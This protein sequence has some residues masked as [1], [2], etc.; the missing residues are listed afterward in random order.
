[1]MVIFD[2]KLN[3]IFKTF[4]DIFSQDQQKLRITPDNLND[5]RTKIE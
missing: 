2:A 4:P 1:M 3:F 5:L